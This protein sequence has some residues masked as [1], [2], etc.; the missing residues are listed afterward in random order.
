MSRFNIVKKCFDAMDT[1]QQDDLID[2]C[3]TIVTNK[4]GRAVPASAKAIPKAKPG[5]KHKGAK[6]GKAIPFTVAGEE[7]KSLGKFCEKHDLNKSTLYNKLKKIKTP[8]AKINF[9]EKEIA[10]KE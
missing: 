8:K 9:L 3:V 4:S 6:K 7:Y 10:E 1:E 2:S 5:P